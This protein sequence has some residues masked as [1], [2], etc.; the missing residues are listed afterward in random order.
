M[1]HLN[2]I[3]SLKEHIK[4]KKWTYH[5][6]A[7]ALQMSESGVKKMLNAKDFSFRRFIQIC[8]ALNISASYLLQQAEQKAIPTK[9]LTSKQQE[10][11]LEDRNLLAVYWRLAIEGL[12]LPE[13]QKAQNISA[14]ELQKHL[15]NLVQAH[16]IY[17]NGNHYLS[18]Q[19]GKFSWS[20][21]SKIAKQLNREWSELTLLRSLKITGKYNRSHRLVATKLSEKSFDNFILKL[22]D[23]LDETVRLSER[24]EMKLPKSQLR[25]LSILTAVVQKGLLD[26]ET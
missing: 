20:N 12:T 6:L 21:D 19:S 2:Y 8:E 4:A 23:L 26:P 25:T 11:L 1:E 3:Q 24:E 7:Q 15:K 5:D 22:N 14:T 18:Y 10:L 17:Q 16:L 9:N 13:I